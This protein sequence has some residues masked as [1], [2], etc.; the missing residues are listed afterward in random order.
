M[1][2]ENCGEEST[3]GL[4][5]LGCA[6]RSTSFDIGE[7]LFPDK[8]RGGLTPPQLLIP[9]SSRLPVSLEAVLGLWL[10]TSKWFDARMF[11]SDSGNTVS[12]SSLMRLNLSASAWNFLLHRDWPLSRNPFANLLLLIFNL[13]MF[14]FWN[15]KYARLY[16][17]ELN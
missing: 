3:H 17:Y 6:S 1:G 15:N 9:L 10:A 4:C 7:F 13:V 8:R 16:I 2:E 11:D 14:S 12:S 5:N